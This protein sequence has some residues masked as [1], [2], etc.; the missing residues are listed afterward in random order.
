MNQQRMQLKGQIADAQHRY[1]ELE[2]RSRGAITLI[3]G[4]LSSE[5]EVVDKKIPEAQSEMTRLS[6]LYEEMRTLKERLA[7]L[8][9]AL[10]G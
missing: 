5:Y 7:E 10:D 1:R 8:G 9:D 4:Y 2:V 3:F 6:A